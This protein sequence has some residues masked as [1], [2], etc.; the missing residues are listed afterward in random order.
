ML[1]TEML[2]EIEKMIEEDDPEI[3]GFRDGEP[4]VQARYASDVFG[5]GSAQ[6]IRAKRIKEQAPERV[7]DIVA[8]KTSVLQ[9]DTE[10]R[11]ARAAEKKAAKQGKADTKER[12]END[13]EVAEYFDNLKMFKE[14]LGIHVVQVEK[15]IKVA[16]FGKFAP[17]SKNFTAN[18]HGQLI[19]LM[20]KVQ[21]LY[22]SLELA[23]ALE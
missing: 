1:A 20:F 6:V 23:I 12:Q 3:Q 9:V 21:N 8:G 15:A 14:Y 22:D 16:E 7:Q 11:E 18:K 4:N 5:V 17:E 10:L 19:D 13:K 2:P